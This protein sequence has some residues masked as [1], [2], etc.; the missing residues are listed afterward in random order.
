MK[1]YRYDVTGMS[2]AA[3]VGHVERAA[4]KALCKLLPKKKEQDNGYEVTVS[5]LTSSM[6]VEIEDALVEKIGKDRIDRALMDEITHAGYHVKATKQANKIEQKDAKETVKQD[7]KSLRRSWL[8]WMISALLTVILMLFSMGPMFGL[9]LISNTVLNALIQLVLTLP[10]LWLNRR[11]FIG[12][13]RALIHFSPNMDSLIAI[14]SGASA[15]YGVFIFVNMIIAQSRGDVET[16]HALAHHLYFESAVMIVT[17]VTLGKNL[18]K[19]ARIRASAAIQ[20]LATMLPETAI[21][22]QNG[23][24]EEIPISAVRVG[25]I[26]LCREGEIV[27]IDGTIVFGKASINESALTGESIPVD[28]KEGDKVN[29]ACTLV[30]GSVR[31]RAEQVGEETA[32]SHV[33]QLLEDAASSRAPVARLADRISRWFVPAVLLI[34]LGTLILWIV[35]TKNVEQALQFAISV[36]V[37]S[38]PCALGLA[39]PTAILVA[40][41]RGAEIG[42]L[43]KSAEALEKL[44]AVNKVCLDKTGTMTEGQPEVVDCL[45]YEEKSNLPVCCEFNKQQKKDEIIALAAAVERH[46]THPLSLAICRSAQKNEIKVAQSTDYK[47]FIGE[48]VSAKINSKI[49]LVGKANLLERYGIDNKQ[50]AWFRRIQTEAGIKGQTA[51]CVV[52]D[53]NVIGAISIADRIREDTPAAIDRLTDMKVST[54]MLTGDNEA[55]AANV[56]MLTGITEHRS[57]LMPQ[58]KEKAIGEAK[59]HFCVA[60]VGDG[61]NDA[62]ALARADVGIAI[63]AGTDVAIDCADVVLTKNSLHSVADAISLS[64]R[65]MMC[66]RENLFWALLY[67]S[68][69]I[70]VA[71]GAF[72]T[73]GVTLNPMIAAGAMSLSSVCVVLNSLRLRR[74]SLESKPHIKEKKPKIKKQEIPEQKTEEQRIEEIFNMEN[75]SKKEIVLSVNGMMCQHCVAHVKK[76]LEAVEGVSAVE[77]S[78]ENKSAIVQADD[79][80]EKSTLVAAVV[81]QGYECE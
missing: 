5:L 8:R 34:S 40:T 51:V 58:D 62:P 69:C 2:C 55:V 3:C 37:I 43:F 28:K 56:A 9:T 70:P 59:E 18:E 67:N 61:I 68:V 41:G 44:H 53:K 66:I 24:E 38:C 81:A 21:I 16:I 72:S 60:M 42:I 64:R 49:C 35:L 7:K 77:V 25:D 79:A 30:Q 13:W 26:V 27:P 80:V 50:T 73:F 74:V 14:G 71:A 33:L 39:T 23:K 48:G 19:G 63:G 75:K 76:A 10:V 31:I 65:T 17:L 6:T 4:N 20:K 11:Y 29:A 78:L 36:L 47:S 45:I 54:L 22:V 57:G 52:Y 32:L 12:G 15:L 1:K 46:S